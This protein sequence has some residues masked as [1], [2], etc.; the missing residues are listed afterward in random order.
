MVS[1]VEFR[2]GAPRFK[3]C[4]RQNLARYSVGLSCT[5]PFIITLLLSQYDLNYVERDVKHQI[6][7][8]SFS[9]EV[10]LSIFL[11]PPF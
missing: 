3:S 10:A 11:L 9:G 7:I 2:S 4:Y 1:A 5:E 6:I 8:I